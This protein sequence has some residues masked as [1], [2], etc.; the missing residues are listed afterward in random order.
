[1]PE[2]K[3]QSEDSRW[4]WDG[5]TLYD[6]QGLVVLTTIAS[7]DELGE[8]DTSIYCDEGDMQ[9]IAL[10]PLYKERHTEMMLAQMGLEA[11]VKKLEGILDRLGVSESI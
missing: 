9:T 11:R 4:R 2:R 6:S 8:I 3:A 7:I 5:D 1:M 10:A